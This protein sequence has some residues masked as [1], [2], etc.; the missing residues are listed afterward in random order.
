[1]LVP[2]TANTPPKLVRL[3]TEEAYYKTANLLTLRNTRIGNLM[4]LPALTVPTAVL[5]CGLML[6]GKPLAE[7][8]LLSLGAAVEVALG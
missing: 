5:S 7:E 2:S 3:A 4:G 1:V 6:M 8:H